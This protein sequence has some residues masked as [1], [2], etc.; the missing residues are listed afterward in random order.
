[1][2]AGGER[3]GRLDINDTTQI[4]HVHVLRPPWGFS[5]V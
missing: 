4:D 1:L 2:L 5:F 3:R